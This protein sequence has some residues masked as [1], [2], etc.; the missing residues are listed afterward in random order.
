MRRSRH[1]R[2]VNVK[3]GPEA[4]GRRRRARG[5]GCRLLL[6]NGGRTHRYDAR[7]GFTGG[8]RL[9]CRLCDALRSRSGMGEPPRLQA[10]P[11]GGLKGRGSAVVSCSRREVGF[12]RRGAWKSLAFRRRWLKRLSSC[13]RRGVAPP[14]RPPNHPRQGPQASSRPRPGADRAF[15]RRPTAHSLGHPDR[16]RPC[17]SRRGPAATRRGAAAGVLCGDRHRNLST[18]SRYLNIRPTRAANGGAA[19]S[20]IIGEPLHNCCTNGHRPR[21]RRQR[22]ATP[23][24]SPKRSACY[25]LEVGAEERTRTSTTLRPQAPEACASASSATSAR[26]GD[27]RLEHPSIPDVR[28]RATGK[29]EMPEG[30]RAR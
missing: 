15:R 14:G 4:C 17:R 16:A 27:N 26:R 12:S 13:L 7:F 29:S 1:S 20:K 9:L 22:R 3:A 21:Q 18:T 2:S 24:R 30:R 6:V 28:P 5:L 25:D 10:K 8:H 11:S 19:D 23:L